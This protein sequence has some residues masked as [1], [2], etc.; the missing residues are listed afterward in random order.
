[1]PQ[2]TRSRVEEQ[3]A[4]M[5]KNRVREYRN[6]KGLTQRELAAAAKTSQQQVQRVEA[7]STPR[8]DLALRLCGALETPLDRL[9]PS[10]KSALTAAQRKGKQK[11]TDFLEDPE[12]EQQMEKAG[13]DMDHAAWTMKYRLRGGMSGFLTLAGPERK[14][15]WNSVNS[16]IGDNDT[17]PF[18]IFDSGDRTIAINRRHLLYCHFLFDAPYE[19]LIENDG[20]AEQVT[21]DEDE[22][23][24]GTLMVYMTDVPEP[25]SFQVDPDSR[26][27]NSSLEEVGVD[28]RTW[29][30]QT[31]LFDLD[32]WDSQDEPHATRSFLDG[33]GETAFFRL[34]DVAM[35][36]VPITYV[37]VEEADGDGTDSDDA[38]KTSGASTTNKDWTK[39]KSNGSLPSHL[40]RR[41][42]NARL[43]RPC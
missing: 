19:H 3:E 9:F 25:I 14:R 4:T 7:G 27:M 41:E 28:D 17:V 31:F 5:V 13:I 37:N 33:D 12:L 8:F 43:V 42:T 29:Q 40:G 23:Q 11:F 30:L 10:T 16:N 22:E 20:D 32:T 38:G 15:V 24:D 21:D 6:R 34:A 35:V 39:G 26:D 1:M 18:V 36:S 2:R